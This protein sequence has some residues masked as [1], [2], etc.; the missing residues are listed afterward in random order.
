MN[1]DQLKYLIVEDSLKVCEGIVER[2]KTYEKW[3]A[4]KFAHHVEDAKTIC[5]QQKPELI[6]MDW[7][8]KGGSAFEVLQFIETIPLYNPYIIFT[9]GYQSE[10]P[11]IPQEIINNYKVDKYLVKP[12]WENLRNN[13]CTYL[14]EAEHKK[15][16]CK[17]KK[18][19]WL[20]DF[21]KYKIQVEIASLICVCQDFENPYCKTLYF[22]NTQSISVKLSWN[23]VIELLESN[24][25]NY[26]ITNSR[27]HIVIKNFIIGYERP[28]V[29][30]ENYA[31]KIEIVK[32]KLHQFEIWLDKYC[33]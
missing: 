7:A 8:L 16:L 5:F 19:I 31:H 30:L 23:E 26:F 4:C 22:N 10:N 28:Y 29:R 6:F 25:V 12:F 1:N 32:D 15:G 13:L 17:N 27:Q 9:T 11:E 20:T 33:H 14:S 2:M 3:I 18:I 24:N 21:H